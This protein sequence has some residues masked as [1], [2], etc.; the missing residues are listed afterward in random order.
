MDTKQSGAYVACWNGA[1]ITCQQLSSVAYVKSDPFTR[2]DNKASA[3]NTVI[4]ILWSQ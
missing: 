2:L 3:Q 4:E 1:R